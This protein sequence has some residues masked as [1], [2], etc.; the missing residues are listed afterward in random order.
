MEEDVRGLPKGLGQIREFLPLLIFV[1]DVYWALLG[2][3]VLT[4][5]D[6]PGVKG[7]IRLVGSI[8]NFIGVSRLPQSGAYRTLVGGV[9]P[10][11]RAGGMSTAF[12]MPTTGDVNCL[13]TNL[14]S[15]LE[16]AK[17]PRINM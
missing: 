8:I 13:T 16:R 11:N 14:A 1:P 5:P 12:T 4:E 17:K 7:E 2:L 9:L 15:S 6:N 3:G 10:F